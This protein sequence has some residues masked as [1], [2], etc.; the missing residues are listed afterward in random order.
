MKGKEEEGVAC[1]R[2]GGKCWLG[3]ARGGLG[4]VGLPPSFD[5]RY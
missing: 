4:L 2:E 1:G 3:D 5:G